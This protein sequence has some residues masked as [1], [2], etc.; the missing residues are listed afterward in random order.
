MIVPVV[1]RHISTNV[2][3]ARTIARSL[4]FPERPRL[5]TQ[6]VASI[7]SSLPKRSSTGETGTVVSGNAEERTHLSEE[8]ADKGEKG[9]KRRRSARR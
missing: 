8:G 7:W 6:T 9:A 4:I 3:K 2:L 1:R 5:S